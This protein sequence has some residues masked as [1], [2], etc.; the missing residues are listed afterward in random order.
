ME[1]GVAFPSKVG[2]YQLVKLAES[3][4]FDQAWFFDSQMIY[5]DV[6]A[7]MALAAHHTSRIKLAT[8]VAVATTRIA[9][10]IAHS[11]A[12][13]AQLAPGRVELGLG[14]GNT[15]RL[16]MG[17]Q[18]VKLSVL[19]R[20]IR[21]IKELLQGKRTLHEYENEKNYIEFLHQHNNF[22]NLKNHIPITL[23]AFGPQTLKFCGEECDGHM[24]WNI[25]K[26][27]LIS[28]RTLLTKAAKEKG[29]NS[30]LPTKGIFP[31]AILREGE[32]KESAS[33][34]KSLAPFITNL[35]HVLCEWDDKLLTEDPKIADLAREYREYVNTIDKNVRHLI[36]HEGHLIYSRPEE[37]KFITPEIA[38]VA[39][40]I[41][42]PDEI[43]ER[44]KI[45]ESS[46]LSHFAFQITDRPQEQIKDFAK[47]IIER[48]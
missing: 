7:T 13:I 19:K 9:P 43:L 42:S 5:S 44:I 18:P 32:T 27:E 31:L 12:T 28:A 20:E 33:V 17:V 45:L 38:D 24:T 48:Y 35:L 8:G 30:E 3:V 21:T 40:M 4:G 2:D 23:S 47:T 16:T 46:G 26:H 29:R 14:N 36:L 1:F 15:A 11:V 34:L 25:S 41:G 6:Y 37:N 22:I 39:A 10:V